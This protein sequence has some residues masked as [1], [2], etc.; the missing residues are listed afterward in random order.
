MRFK[1]AQ[2]EQMTNLKFMLYRTGLSCLLGLAVIGCSSAVETALDAEFKKME[3]LF[4]VDP[5]AGVGLG[6][7]IG[8]R[9]CRISNEVV[10]TRCLA[11]FRETILS[12]SLTEVDY[13][14]RDRQLSLFPKLQ[15]VYL[16]VLWKCGPSFVGSLEF[17]LAFLNRLQNERVYPPSKSIPNIVR[18][19]KGP[20]VSVLCASRDLY[21]KHLDFI[22][23]HNLRQLEERFNAASAQ[24]SPNDCTKIRQQIE[25]LVRTNQA[26]DRRGEI[27]NAEDA[28]TDFVGRGMWYADKRAIR[29]GLPLFAHLR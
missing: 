8:A 6:K 11:H 21:L 26:I 25:A 24:L 28:E 15:D 14:S 27:E 7:E 2:G 19:W 29:T 22:Y 10:R 20:C 13:T 5:G 1:T 3:S 23:N 4:Q 16:D 12:M 17:R 18:N 9:I